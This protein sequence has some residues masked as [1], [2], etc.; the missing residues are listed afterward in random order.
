MVFTR[1]RCPTD[2]G[3]TERTH[4]TLF[5][6]A[7]AGQTWSSEEQLWRGLDERRP[8]LNEVLPVRALVNQAPL[9][10][11]PKART[12]GRPHRPEREEELLQLERMDAYL[13]QGRWFR[14]VQAG[15]FHLG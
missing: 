1:K 5:A 3:V 6:Q 10:A 4:Q 8:V 7:L 9:R 15:V 11:Y 2:H 13:A 14:P 12:T